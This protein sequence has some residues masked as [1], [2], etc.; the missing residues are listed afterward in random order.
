[1]VYLTCPEC[2]SSDVTLDMYNEVHCKE[3]RKSFPMY[4]VGW[5][6]ESG[7]VPIHTKVSP[8][9]QSTAIN[10]VVVV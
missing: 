9:N 4:R 3:C 10:F 2:G 5:V 6:S 8:Q 7:C 1:M